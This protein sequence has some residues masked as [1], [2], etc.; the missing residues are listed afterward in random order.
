LCIARDGQRHHHTTDSDS[1]R[2]ARFPDGDS[3]RFGTR[4]PNC[5]KQARPKQLETRERET[6]HECEAEAKRTGLLLLV[7]LHTLASGRHLYTSF[8]GSQRKSNDY[9]QY[10]SV[11]RMILHLPAAAPGD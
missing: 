7:A 4:F 2:R 6:C 11:L 8:G 5:T 3:P 9:Y 1:L 10:L